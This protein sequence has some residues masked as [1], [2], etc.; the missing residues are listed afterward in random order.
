MRKTGVTQPRVKVQ[1]QL[2]STLVLLS[3]RCAEVRRPDWLP[4]GLPRVS[5]AIMSMVSPNKQLG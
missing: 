5:D 4:P 1:A 2:D 3:G